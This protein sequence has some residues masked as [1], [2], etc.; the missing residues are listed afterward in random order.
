MFTPDNLFSVGAQSALNTAL[1]EMQKRGIR[2]AGLFDVEVRIQ[3]KPEGV[4]DPDVFDDH[5]MKV[6]MVELESGVYHIEE[7]VYEHRRY[8]AISVETSMWQPLKRE[9]L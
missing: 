7:V 9:V 4:D 5:V 2:P 6:E 8:N 3:V 1:D